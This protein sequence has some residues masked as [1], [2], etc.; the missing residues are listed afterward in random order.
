MTPRHALRL[1]P[2]LSV[3]LAVVAVACG[4]E[5]SR[6]G[7]PDLMVEILVSPTPA[8]AADTRVVVLLTDRGVAPDSAVVS[9]TAEGPGSSFDTGPLRID[10]PGR[11]VSAPLSFSDP[12]DWTMTVSVRMLDGRAATFR[13]PVT[14]SGPGVRRVRRP[15]AAAG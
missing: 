10:A 14:V 2:T 4:S 12:G 1:A 15:A 7:D 8:S 6:T 9:L 11:F 5:R 13:R 3:A